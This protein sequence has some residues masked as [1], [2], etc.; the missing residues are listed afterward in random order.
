MPRPLQYRSQCYGCPVSCSKSEEKFR[1]R[2]GAIGSAI[3]DAFDDPG[4]NLSAV[5]N[6]DCLKLLHLH[7]WLNKHSMKSSHII[8]DEI[9]QDVMFQG[10][11]FHRSETLAGDEG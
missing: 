4:G 5:R 3:L 6:H 10:L 2:K 7:C 8:V 11:P 1:A 9:L